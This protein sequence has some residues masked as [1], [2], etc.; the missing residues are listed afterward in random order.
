MIFIFRKSIIA[1]SDPLHLSIIILSFYLSGLLIFYCHLDLQLKYWIILIYIFLFIILSS[2]LSGIK[3]INVK[4]LKL[5]KKKQVQLSYVL[6]IISF[7]NLIV[8]YIYGFMPILHGTQSRSLMGCVPIPSLVVFSQF[9]IFT[10]LLVRFFS[11]YPFVR[12]INDINL[13]TLVITNI[14]GGSKSSVLTILFLIIYYH[15]LL[16][17]KKK[18][19]SKNIFYFNFYRRLKVSV[20]KIRW[21]FLYATVLVTITIPFYLYYVGVGK[22]F[23]EICQNIAFRLFSGFDAFIYV[24]L[25]DIDFKKDLSLIEMWFYPFLKNLFYT[26]E[27]QSAGLYITSRVYGDVDYAKSALN[28]NSNLIL[29][30]LYSQKHIVIL[31]IIFLVALSVFKM[32]DYALNKSGLT[33]KNLFVFQFAVLTPLA[34]FF[35]A[36]FYFVRIELFLIFYFMLNT[37]WNLKNICHKYKY[38]LY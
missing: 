27:Y 29:E 26:P 12:R 21:A 14:L 17:T 22:N 24:L 37:I 15:F 38:L 9:S 31:V 5:S 23:K 16:I 7:L 4:F 11:E 2:I 13:V 28:P 33:L 1:I 18:A 36:S 8:N 10:V 25:N 32:R 19:C 34:V 35:D 20:G 30:L 6:L 3:S